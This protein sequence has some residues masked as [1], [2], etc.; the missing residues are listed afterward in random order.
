VR[1]EVLS[2][3][4]REFV[5]AARVVGVPEGWILVR[6]LLPNFLSVVIVTA[7]LRVAVNLL[8]EAGLSY[9]GLGVQPPLPSW[10]NMV[11]DGKGVLRTAPWVSIF[12]GVFI[13]L[14]VMAFNLVGDGLRDAFD[15]RMQARRWSHTATDEAGQGSRRVFNNASVQ[16]GSPS[17]G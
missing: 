15:P 17:Y 9:L 5:H 7:T 3:R 16:G 4:T 11:A 14:T 10:G 2:Q 13:F 1:G 12:P 6:H 8:V